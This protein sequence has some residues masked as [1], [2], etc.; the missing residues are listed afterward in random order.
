[1]RIGIEGVEVRMERYETFV[2]D[3]VMSMLR[4]KRE[5]VCGVTT[6]STTAANHV[7]TS[8]SMIGWLLNHQYELICAVLCPVMCCSLLPC[9]ANTDH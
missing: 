1:M 7:S 8:R 4:R 9:D 5:S 3:R 6:I 2:S